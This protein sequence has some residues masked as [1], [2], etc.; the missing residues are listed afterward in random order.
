MS[1]GEEE[2]AQQSNFKK[3]FETIARIMSGSID[4]GT[5]LNSEATNSSFNSETSIDLNSQVST[6]QTTSSCSLQ[7][8]HAD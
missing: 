7:I 2:G 3:A 4:V 5:T 1:S 6:S 8:K